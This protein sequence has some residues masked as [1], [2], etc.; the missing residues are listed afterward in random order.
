MIN[1]YPQ[2]KHAIFALGIWIMVFKMQRLI[3]NEDIGSPK[4]LLLKN[5]LCYN[6]VFSHVP[7]V[8]YICKT[9]TTPVYFLIIKMYAAKL[10]Y[11][12]YPADA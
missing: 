7:K 9:V 11:S 12:Q 5:V 10:I 6:Q 2:S 8:N 4:C 1:K 3:S